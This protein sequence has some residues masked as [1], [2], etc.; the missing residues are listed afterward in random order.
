[1]FCI[2][3]GPAKILNAAL[4]RRLNGCGIFLNAAWSEE[5]CPPSASR[6][7]H[8]PT[9]QNAGCTMAFHAN[10]TKPKNSIFYKLL[11]YKDF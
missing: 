1:M 8:A 7:V 4:A 10:C 11:I 6:L 5:Q 2:H 3:W 9:T